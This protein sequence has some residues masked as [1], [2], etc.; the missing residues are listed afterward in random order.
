MALCI[1]NLAKNLNEWAIFNK[2]DSRIKLIEH[3]RTKLLEQGYLTHEEALE[4]E[5]LLVEA[6]T[7][8]E[9]LI[10]SQKKKDADKL[11]SDE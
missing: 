9:Y 1:I 5:Q 8:Y 3:Q 10:K 6:Q 4:L 2:W 7:D 11:E